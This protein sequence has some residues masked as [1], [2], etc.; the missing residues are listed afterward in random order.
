MELSDAH[1]I[2]FSVSQLID[3]LAESPEIDTDIFLRALE[4]TEENFSGQKYW[5]L[6]KQEGSAM[7][8][9]F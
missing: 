7:L 4:H 1:A 3:P 8:W 6:H 5:F 2:S 9:F